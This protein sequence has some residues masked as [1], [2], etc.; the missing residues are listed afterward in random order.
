MI[1]LACDDRDLVQNPILIKYI[2]CVCVFVC[3]IHLLMCKGR[4]RIYHGGGKKFMGGSH[5]NGF[6]GEKNQF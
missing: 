6:D 3:I 5:E 4:M 1:Y 2:M